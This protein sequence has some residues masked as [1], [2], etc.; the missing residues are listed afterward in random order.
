MITSSDFVH[1]DFTDHL[2]QAGISYTIRNLVGAV[3]YQK[4]ITYDRIRLGVAEIAVELAFRRHLSRNGIP[5]GSKRVRPFTKPDHQ[6]VYIG[7]RKCEIISYLIQHRETIHSIG[8]DP[9]LLLQIPVQAPDDLIKTDHIADTDLLIFAFATSLVTT[10]RDELERAQKASQPTY[11]IHL[12][13]KLWSHSPSWRSLGQMAVHNNSHEPVTLEMLGSG[14]SHELLEEQLLLLPLQKVVLETEFYS[15]NLIHHVQCNGTNVE[16]SS[17]TVEKS[18]QITRYDW[19]NIWVYGMEIILAGYITFG[20]YKRIAR[21]FK[22]WKRI[23]LI[24]KSHSSSCAL[25]IKELHA[26]PHLFQSAKDWSV[27]Y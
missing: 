11:C 25:K 14:I 12:L 27:N 3:A 4:S 10:T 7:G 2:T 24:G 8:K 1:L 15:L 13:P 19:E 26:L 18:Y 5:H 17:P 22:P 20:D 9:T 21:P 16:I 23:N 6:S